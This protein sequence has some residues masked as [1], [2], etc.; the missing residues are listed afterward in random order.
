MTTLFRKSV[1]A[2]PFAAPS[3]LA[4]SPAVPHRLIAALRPMT[5]STTYYPPL[6][7]LSKDLSAQTYAVILSSPP[8]N[9]L[10]PTLLRQLQAHLLHLHADQQ[11]YLNHGLILTSTFPNIMSAGLDWD[12]LIHNEETESFQDFEIRFR[13]YLNL[14][15]DCCKLLLTISM[16]TIAVVRGACP[17]GGTVLSLCCDERIGVSSPSFLMG[18]NEVAIGMN[19]PSWIH[20]LAYQTLGQNSKTRRF[21]QQGYLVRSA[22]EALELGYIDKLVYS[23]EDIAENVGSEL[24]HYLSQPWTARTLTKK[25]QNQHVV[26]SMGPAAID[27]LWMTV[28]SAEFQ[29]KVKLFKQKIRN[30]AKD[31]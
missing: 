21:L 6:V 14:F 20:H 11:S 31:A 28:G 16:P 17:A 1:R 30:R 19:L 13:N 2:L 4:A 12:C 7:R 8:V 15:Q 18:L 22:E 23:N 9:A 29:E 25:T 10:T 24:R 5:S 26:D 3:S 27:D